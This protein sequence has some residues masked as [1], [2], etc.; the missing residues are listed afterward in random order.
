MHVE[1][2]ILIPRPETEE[3]VMN[4]I[5]KMEKTKN[6]IVA[7]ARVLDLCTGSGCLSLALA[8]HAPRFL[9]TGLDI[10]KKAI[11]VATAN[12]DR[13]G[14]TNTIFK[15]VDIFDDNALEQANLARY[16]L[17][18]SNP[19]YI[20]PKDYEKL[21]RSVK[22]YEDRRA[23]VGQYRAHG[24]S[25][26]SGPVSDQDGLDFYRRIREI[27]TRYLAPSARRTLTEGIPRM[28]LEF[29]KGQDESVQEI[30]GAYNSKIVKDFNDIERTIEVY[31]MKRT[32]P[33]L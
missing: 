16:D 27:A 2:P 4:L 23:L 32:A 13:L 7:P 18:V 15:Q 21:D 9:V 5:K 3:W 25:K 17:I 24:K 6:D 28:V 22:D 30:F 12:S 31:S 11:Q 1:P 29:G 10:S 26:T 19:P 33:K 8:K 20:T 14:F